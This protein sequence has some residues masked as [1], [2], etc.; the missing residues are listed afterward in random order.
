MT[1]VVFT[2]Q[3]HYLLERRKIDWFGDGK[4][5]RWGCAGCASRSPTAL[6]QSK[7]HKHRK[8]HRSMHSSTAQQLCASEWAELQLNTTRLALA[9]TYRAVRLP[10]MEAMQRDV[11]TLAHLDTTQWH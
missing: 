10:A 5:R 2:A 9:A 3:Q 4:L 6:H 11:T 1:L 8:C 7:V